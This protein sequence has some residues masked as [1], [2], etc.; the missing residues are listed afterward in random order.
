MASNTHSWQP[1]PRMAR[2]RPGR[3]RM[4]LGKLTNGARGLAFAFRRDRSVAWKLPVFALVLAAALYLRNWVDVVLIVVATMVLLA[5][6]LFNTAIEELSN[7][8][9]PDFDAR[10]G[11]VKD[12]AAAAVM[13][14]YVAWLSVIGYEVVRFGSAW[15]AP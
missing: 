7:V 5:A 2:T 8:V 4:G 11:R 12:M 9:Q 1:T 13:L 6:E 14:C 3:T 15:G 10:I